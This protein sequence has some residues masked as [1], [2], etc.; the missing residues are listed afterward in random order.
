MSFYLGNNKITPLYLGGVEIAEAFFGSVRVY[1]DYNPLNLPPHTIRCKFSAG[2]VP[3][4]G[5]SQTLVD[6]SENIWDI[7]LSSNDWI[8]LFYEI[9]P[10]VN[11]IG[12]NTTGVVNMR[13]MFYGCS[14]LI[15]VPLFDTSSVTDMTSMFKNCT[16]LASV[17]LFDTSSVTTMVDM[18]YWCT[19]LKIVPL[20]DTSLVT[21]MRS[22]FD[23]CHAVESGALAL[24]RQASTQ[25]TPP[26]YHGRTFTDCGRDTVTG[27][28]ELARIPA[29][30]GGT[31]T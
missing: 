12:A 22:M 13:S 20:F 21:D 14:D 9:L 1:P 26:T 8:G 30:W 7:Y 19:S 15:S 2:Y 16:N 5:D 25:S 29:S 24:Y 11:V 6:A 10:L 3:S 28:A 27:A 4:M 18:F 17:P 23:G 31:A